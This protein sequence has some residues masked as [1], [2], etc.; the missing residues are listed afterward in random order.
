MWEV[1]ALFTSEEEGM[2]SSADV[3]DLFSSSFHFRYSDVLG[4]MYANGYVFTSRDIAEFH[5]AV[6][7][8][9]FAA[10]DTVLRRGRVWG[11]DGEASLPC[12]TVR[13]P[14]VFARAEYV[15]KMAR[16]V[17]QP[18]RADQGC[19]GTRSYLPW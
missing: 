15:F 19:L 5:K 12:V 4:K 13:I 3:G 2:D 11:G 9:D 18:V 10:A 1:P 6:T 16:N 8:E 14:D 7:C 17:L